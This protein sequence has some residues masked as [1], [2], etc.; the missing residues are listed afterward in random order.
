MN[1]G[2]IVQVGTPEE[3]YN[4][5]INV[6]VADFIG[7]TN[8]VD[9]E[10]VSGPS[11]EENSGIVEFRGRDGAVR[12]SCVWSKAVI[13]NKKVILSLRQEHLNMSL[14]ERENTD[15]VFKAT[16]INKSF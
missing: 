14:S 11:G 4:R 6:F 12:I 3:I 2:K 1:H 8:L 16:V 5:P 13:H 10:I 9:G 15:N 7:T